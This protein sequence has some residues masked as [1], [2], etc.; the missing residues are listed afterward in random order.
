MGI[1]TFNLFGYIELIF[2]V[3]LFTVLICG[4]TKNVIYPEPEDYT[5]VEGIVTN[6]EAVTSGGLFGG[7]SYNIVVN[8][9]DGIQYLIHSRDYYFKYNIGDV[10]NESVESYRYKVL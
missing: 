6:R 7:V 9:T 10:F 1:K 4:M 3:A 5:E 8:G 2:F